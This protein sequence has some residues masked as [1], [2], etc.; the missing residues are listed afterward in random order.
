[1]IVLATASSDAV[2]P[3]VMRA[4]HMAI[5]TLG[6]PCHPDRLFLRPRRLLDLPDARHGVHRQRLQHAARVHGPPADPR[7][8]A[9]DL[10]GRARRPARRSSSSPPPSS[11]VP[12]IPA[13]G[14]CWCFRST[15]TSAVARAGRRDRRKPVATVVIAAWEGDID[16]KRAHRVLNGEDGDPSEVALRPRA[17][18]EP[19]LTPTRR[20]WSLARSAAS[21]GCGPGSVHAFQMDSR[22]FPDGEF[23]AFPRERP[24]PTKARP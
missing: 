9:P 6:R 19:G 10:Q 13:I 22:C 4:R 1:M 20:G 5:R 15:G 11:A 14:W 24:D 23:R 18:V 2:L 7:G 21:G 12:V 8:G 16:R 17:R 3:Q